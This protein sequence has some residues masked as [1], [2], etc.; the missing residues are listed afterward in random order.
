MYFHEANALRTR[1]SDLTVGGGHLLEVGD[2]PDEGDL[3][4]RNDKIYVQLHPSLCLHTKALKDFSLF[5]PG[6]FR[7]A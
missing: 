2:N 5:P 4:I 3:L 6:C 1:S 7:A